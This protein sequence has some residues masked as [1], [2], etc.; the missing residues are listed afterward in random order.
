M[1]RKGADPKKDIER[2]IQAVKQDADGIRTVT[3]NTVK[4]QLVRR[5]FNTGGASEGGKIG[6]YEQ[7]T[8]R[9]RKRG[10]RQTAYVDLEM[11]GTLRRSISTGVSEGKVVLGMQDQNE[12][13]ISIEN[14]RVKIKG[15]SSFSTVENAILQEKNFNTEI[16]APSKEELTRG[17]KTVIK[18]L[19]RVVQKALRLS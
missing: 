2:I 18:E 13:K 11:T 10:G 5:I 12:P 15:T 1:K 3:F 4:G 16:F 6:L 17:E 19:D 14:G 9:A 7:S 8:Q